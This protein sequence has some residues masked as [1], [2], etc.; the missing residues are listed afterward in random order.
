[1]R[2]LSKKHPTAVLLLLCY[3]GWLA[4]FLVLH[5]IGLVQNK[6]LYANGTFTTQQLTLAD[7]EEPVGF[8]QKENKMV[9]LA[10]YNSYYS[11]ENYN[12][13][14]SITAD[15]QLL[16]KDAA[17]RVDSLQVEIAYAT[18]PR[19]QTVFYAK[20]GQDYTVRQMVYPQQVQTQ[21]RENDTLYTST[22]WLP[23]SG[24][25]SL[26]LDPDTVAGRQ[27]Q[28]TAITL[29]VPRPWTSFFVPTPGEI[30]AFAVVPGLLA[31]VFVAARQG[32]AGLKKPAKGGS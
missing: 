13:L 32:L 29:N 6:V 25:Q 2:Q 11:E 4:V 15:P 16:L 26:R 19:T 31:A 28:I 8:A 23:P 9:P 30:A 21:E 27:M 20:P 22:F 24:G 1:M 3:G 12:T 10:L 7:F 18:P 17:Q 14:V 5:T